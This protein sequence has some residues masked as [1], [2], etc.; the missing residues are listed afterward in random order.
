MDR[1]FIAAMLNLVVRPR[2]RGYFHRVLL[3]RDM[4]P[5]LVTVKDYSSLGPHVG[6][7][8]FV[9]GHLRGPILKGQVR[10]I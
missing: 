8:V 5:P 1:V 3:R 2:L 4:V 9:S 7:G 10:I 6:N